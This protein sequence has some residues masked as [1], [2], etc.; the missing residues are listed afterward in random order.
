MFF[1]RFFGNYESLV[2]GQARD[3]MADMMGGVGENIE[4]SNIRGDS[5]KKKKLFKEMLEAFE[6]HSLMAASMGVILLSFTS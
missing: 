6:N 4:I 5:K 2:S 3:A 1:E